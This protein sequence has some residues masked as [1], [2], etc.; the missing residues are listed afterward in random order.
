M[1]EYCLSAFPQPEGDSQ[2][3]DFSSKQ[4]IFA[5]VPQLKF[6]GHP[7]PLLCCDIDEIDQGLIGW[8]DRNNGYDYYNL[9]FEIPHPSMRRTKRINMNTRFV[10]TIADVEGYQDVTEEIE[11]E[12][13]GAIQR[14]T[15]L[16]SIVKHYPTK[17]Q[18]EA[19]AAMADQ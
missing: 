15:P 14:S 18:M 10:A 16:Y 5:Y 2:N 11:V 9:M 4:E 6:P 7:F 13:R 3:I 19:A 8:N 12:T 17:W 1:T